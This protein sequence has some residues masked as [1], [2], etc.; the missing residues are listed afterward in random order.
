[1]QTAALNLICTKCVLRACV[2]SCCSQRRCQTW[3]RSPGGLGDVATATDH[4]CFATSYGEIS[5]VTSF[6]NR[7][8]HSLHIYVC[9]YRLLT[10]RLRSAAWRGSLVPYSIR[11]SCA[12]KT[13]TMTKKHP[14]MESG[15]LENLGHSNKE[16]YERI[17]R[18]FGTLQ[19]TLVY[20][21][22][23][24]TLAYGGSQQRGAPPRP[25]VVKGN[26]LISTSLNFQCLIILFIN[27]HLAL[28]L[29][30]LHGCIIMKLY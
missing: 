25:R 22:E 8:D 13:E 20:D 28:F 26:Y 12:T 2:C 11:S 30:R 10:V 15:L 16:A 1:M 9:N 19:N 29:Q 17:M 5:N 21:S 24:G 3:Q 23:V 6:A 4:W 18:H 14:K 27:Y 7:Q